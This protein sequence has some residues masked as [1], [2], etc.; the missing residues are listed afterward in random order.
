MHFIVSQ[1]GKDKKKKKKKGEEKTKRRQKL[2]SGM[3]RGADK[4]PIPRERISEW[5]KAQAK[6]LVLSESPLQQN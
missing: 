1:R 6:K 4:F 2:R 3:C 5:E